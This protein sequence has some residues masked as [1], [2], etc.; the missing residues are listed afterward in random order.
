MVRQNWEPYIGRR[1]PLLH[2]RLSWRLLLHFRTLESQKWKNSLGLQVSPLTLLSLNI[3]RKGHI[4]DHCQS[5]R[6]FWFRQN[7]IRY[8]QSAS[9][10]IHQRP[11]C[12]V[13]TNGGHTNLKLLHADFTFHTVSTK[14]TKRPLSTE[15]LFDYLTPM[16]KG[17]SAI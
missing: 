11:R 2:N 10:H 15:A 3:Y 12:N 16:E 4:Q 6:P 9:W 8:Q 1:C 17:W 13:A 7:N 5:I 14:S